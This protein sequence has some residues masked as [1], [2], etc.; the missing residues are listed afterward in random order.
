MNFS[1][2]ESPVIR[3]QYI[4]AATALVEIDSVLFV[5]D[6]ALSPVG[7]FQSGHITLTKTKVS[8]KEGVV[9]P[10][11]D[12]VLLSHDQHADNFDQAGQEYSLS[13]S[14]VLTTKIGATRQKGSLRGLAPWD[15]VTIVTKS[16]RRLRITATPARHGPFGIEKI[17]G[18]VVGFV[19]TDLETDQDLVYVTGDTCW[20]QG[21]KEVS[22]RFSPKVILLYGGAAQVR[23]PINLTANTND[24]IEIACHFPRSQIVPVHHDGWKHFTQTQMD[25]MAA[26]KVVGIDHRL[27]LVEEEKWLEF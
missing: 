26:F 12:V 22:E 17:T 2:L 15:H 7:D 4:S 21:V 20:F 23:G 13:A 1:L 11:A 6:P 5:T 27:H 16:K 3:I 14:L 24:A 10:R 19:I 9:M 25:L 18:D 8:L